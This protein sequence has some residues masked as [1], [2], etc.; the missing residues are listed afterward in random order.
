MSNN[1]EYGA[2]RSLEEFQAVR[3]A[4]H[5]HSRDNV[6]QLTPGQPQEK[7]ALEECDDFLRPYMLDFEVEKSRRQPR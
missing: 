1:P 2:Y 7:K 5:S 6:R 3:Q 4:L